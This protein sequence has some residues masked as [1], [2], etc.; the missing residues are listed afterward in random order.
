[1]DSSK[2]CR[3]CLQEASQFSF[4]THNKINQSTGIVFAELLTIC[5]Q[6]Y[7]IHDFHNAA[8]PQRICED[9]EKKT[10]K[11]YPFW[12]EVKEN[13]ARLAGEKV[14][15]QQDENDSFT[16]IFESVDIDATIKDEEEETQMELAV[17]QE[18][19]QYTEAEEEE[20]TLLEQNIE[21]VQNEAASE[22]ICDNCS[23]RYK[24]RSGLLAH[25]RKAHK[26]SVTTKE[27]K[28]KKI[29]ILKTDTTKSEEV[30]EQNR[31]IREFYD[32]SCE[33][34]PK[35][36]KFGTWG[37][38]RAHMRTMHNEPNASMVCCNKRLIEKRKLLSHAML[39]T[40]PD[41]LK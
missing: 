8:F 32:L 18:P 2:L 7:S 35:L 28:Q 31:I 24:T 33:K 6:L 20:H 37:E 40:N 13:Q 29:Q 17:A 14:I 19:Y 25:L 11:F 36:P 1:M 38:W 41:Q 16:T 3:L 22:F 30:E 27:T 5:E 9:C 39:H 26:Q 4:P 21:L 10:V 12:F 34:C 15:D 23:A